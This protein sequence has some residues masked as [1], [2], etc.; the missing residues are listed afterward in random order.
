MP[1]NGAKSNELEQGEDVKREN[2]KCNAPISDHSNLT[3]NSHPTSPNPKSKDI[4][5]L[6]IIG[7]YLMWPSFF[8]LI[9]T[10]FPLASVKVLCAFY[11][12][13]P[14]QTSIHLTF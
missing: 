10:C 7:N 14:V 1:V 13:H 6:G 11:F 5:Q 9:I 2:P 12:F 8:G 3:P 4:N